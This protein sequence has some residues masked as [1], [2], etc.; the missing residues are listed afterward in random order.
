MA[1]ETARAKGGVCLS[2]R[3]E[4]AKSP[5]LWKC[6]EDHEWSASFDSVCNNSG[7]WC[8]KCAAAKYGAGFRRHSL[9]TAQQLAEKRGGRCLSVAYK[10]VRTKM[11]WEC[12]KG[13][14]WFAIMHNM[15]T[16][17]AWC[18]TCAGRPILSLED[19][20]EIA[21]ERGGECVS[22][23]YKDNSTP[24]TWQCVEGHRWNACL[25]AVKDRCSWCPTCLLTTESLCYL[26][27]KT[28]F[29]EHIFIKTRSLPWLLTDYGHMRLELDMWCEEL[30]LAIEYN[31]QQ[32]YG[33]IPRFH[34]NG[35]AD[36]RRQQ[37]NDALKAEACLDQGV[38]LIIVPY[39]VHQSNPRYFAKRRALAI[40]IADA[41]A[42]LGY[43]QGTHLSKEELLAALES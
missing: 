5:M 41:I 10:S 25:H 14:R 43:S 17:G 19:A 26:I 32:H 11:E 34:P 3:Y 35:E 2:E 22:K 6:A 7:S 27:V 31:G 28:L 42:D 33:V 40:F 20:R 1:R 8:R 12:A 30:R 16:N 29:P 24:L 18:A 4:K 21:R 38:C 36:L 9:E 15:M 37:A 13:H 23:E 39:W